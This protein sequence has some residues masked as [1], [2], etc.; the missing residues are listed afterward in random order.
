MGQVRARCPGTGEIKNSLNTISMNGV[1]LKIDRSDFEK[2]FGVILSNLQNRE[3]A[4]AD[5][6][7]IGRESVR[8]N[9]HEG[10]RPASWKAL[11]VRQGQPLR[12]KNR[13]MNSITST[14]GT[15][16]VNI[17]TNVEYAAVHH[18]GARKYSFGSF[19]FTVPAHDRLIAKGKNRGK[20]TRVR[21]HTRTMKLPWGDIPAR[22]FMLL[23][24]DDIL[25]M[26]EILAKH[27][28][29]GA[30]NEQI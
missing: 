29:Q 28:V 15:N 4:M 20:K 27:T 24:D 30:G 18:F 19:T 9:F 6:G 17:G 23:Q 10:G 26:Q 25:D 1:T 7:A 13:L 2:T 3:T 8:L 21:E 12:D 22:P 14:V 16:S 5:I 11:K